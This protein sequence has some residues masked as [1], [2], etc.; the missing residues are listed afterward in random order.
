MAE[1]AQAPRPGRAGLPRAHQAQETPNCLL[2]AQ[3]TELLDLLLLLQWQGQKSTA[4][5]AKGT[6]LTYAG[7]KKR[8]CRALPLLAF[9]FFL[10]LPSPPS[11]LQK[12]A[13]CLQPGFRKK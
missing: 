10:H 7:H 9:P 13:G 4:T 2:Q 5:P 3:G 8:E 11:G 6:A 12:D 1:P